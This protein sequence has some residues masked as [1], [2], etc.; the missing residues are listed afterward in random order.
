MELI[1]IFSKE[2]GYTIILQGSIHILYISD[3]HT[4]KEIIKIIHKDLKNKDTM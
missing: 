1:N 3:K 2:A 4:E